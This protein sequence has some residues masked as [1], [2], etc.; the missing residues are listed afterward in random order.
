[1]LLLILENCAPIA[2]HSFSSLYRSLYETVVVLGPSI[3]PV[4][5]ST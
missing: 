1:M 5:R 2:P 3:V 4:A